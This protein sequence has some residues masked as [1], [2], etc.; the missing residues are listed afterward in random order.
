MVT[1]LLP[2]Y[3]VEIDKFDKESWHNN[4][5]KFAD[6][7]I[8]QT[9]AYE[10]INSGEKNLSHMLLIKNGKAVA[11]AQARIVKIPIVNIGVA[12]VRWGPM[13]HL[14]GELPNHEVFTQAIR[15]LRNEYACRHRLVVRILPL[16][17]NDQADIFYPILAQEGYVHP[18]NEEPQRTL[19]IDLNRSLEELRKGLDQK[20]R[21]RLNRGEKN[22]LNIIEGFD[23]NLFR[24]FLETYG[25]MH[26]RKNFTETVD[27]HQFRLMQ[28]DLPE[29]F[30]M[31]I[32]IAICEGKPAAGV[33]CSSIGDMGVYLFGATS[34]AGLSAQGS[35]ALQWRA[36]NWLKESGVAWYNLNGINPIIN[37]GTYHFK[38]GMCGK[39]GKDIKYLGTYD[40]FNGVVMR[41]AFK[42]AEFI[43]TTYRE[44][45]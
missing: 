23:D 1:Q 39:N 6:A 26:D 40:A 32:F 5:D 30:K 14:Q 13:W 42:L 31:K 43:R 34:D 17:Y 28:S 16:L 41:N 25:E 22:N 35:Y 18:P 10:E 15:A 2:G 33:I 11:A 12:Y 27:V 44:K 4:L 24:L 38:S 37:P 9:W 21:N 29:S 45:L 36:L 7:N 3:S 20:W 19:V 8:Y